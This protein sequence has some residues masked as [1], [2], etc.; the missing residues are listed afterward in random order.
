MSVC[1]CVCACVCE[2]EQERAECERERDREREKEEKEET[3]R[4]SVAGV[5]K[6]RDESNGSC[7]ASIK[8]PGLNAQEHR[9]SYVSALVERRAEGR[10]GKRRERERTAEA[11][12]DRV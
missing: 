4:Y 7:G 10:G 5:E 12:W 3:E 8:H 6:G 9:C 11:H 2:R 1:V